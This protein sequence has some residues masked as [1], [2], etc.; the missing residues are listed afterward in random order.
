MSEEAT[1]TITIKKIGEQWLS[2]HQLVNI[3]ELVAAVIMMDVGRD[4]ILRHHFNHDHP[5][6]PEAGH[7]DATAEN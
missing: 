4:L 1:I 6:H 3:D 2:E 5:H 7:G